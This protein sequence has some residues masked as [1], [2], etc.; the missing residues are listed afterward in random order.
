[1]YLIRPKVGSRDI[2]QEPGLKFVPPF[3]TVRRY[4]MTVRQFSINKPS[5]SPP[6]RGIDC[7]SF[8]K[9][10]MACIL[11]VEYRLDK[12]EAKNFFG[13]FGEHAESTVIEHVQTRI[14]N[15]VGEAIRMLVPQYP[16]SYL[17]HHREE[18]KNNLLIVLGAKGGEW[19]P[20]SV[21]VGDGESEKDA[22]LPKPI[23][24]VEMPSIPG[25]ID[26][27]EAGIMLQEVSISFDL[28][29]DYLKELVSQAML[30]QSLET[31]SLERRKNAALHKA[32]E[33]KLAFSK[34][35]E[36]ARLEIEAIRA[37]RWKNFVN[38]SL[39]VFLERW[40]GQLPQL[41]S[42][43]GGAAV[44]KFLESI[45]SRGLFDSVTNSTIVPSANVPVR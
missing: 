42:I 33:E 11:D 12:K 32:V 18:L 44:G 29:P 17:L 7:R 20:G 10:I 30:I 16:V 2:S 45:G 35:E 27:A 43:D 1:M 4:S 39:R 5:S 36:A 19:L 41:L 26:L 31:A 34:Q 21:G 40:N 22:N 23:K 13:Q 6:L 38:P 37:E 9:V 15:R 3:S 8:D 25:R 24:R 28:P 14:E